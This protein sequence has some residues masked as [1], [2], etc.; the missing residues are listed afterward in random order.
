M[1]GLTNLCVARS[2]PHP[3]LVTHPSR[4]MSQN[5]MLQWLMDAVRDEPIEE[6]TNR[7][8]AT[9]VLLVGFAAIHTSSMVSIVP[10]MKIANLYTNFLQSFTHALYY[11]AA[12]PQYMKPMREEVE[13]V[14]AH[15]GWCKASLQKMRKVDS[16]LKEC[17]RVEGLGLRK[18]MYLANRSPAHT[19][20]LQSSSI[21]KLCRT[22]RSP[23][24]RLF[25]GEASS[26][27]RPQ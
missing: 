22:S 11:L 24:G 3:S 23:M 15:D 21:A 13:A 18:L 5:D 10:A 1:T 17:Q 14:I 12:N 19:E 25:L 2:A 9:R 6:Q 16:F 20:L 4:L 26:A 7:G 27:P 8:L